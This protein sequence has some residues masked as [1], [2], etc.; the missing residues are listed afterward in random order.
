MDQSAAAGQADHAA[1]KLDVH[2]SGVTQPGQR[3][4]W[5][6][7]RRA[8]PGLRDGPHVVQIPPRPPPLLRELHTQVRGERGDP[9]AAP[10]VLML[11]VQDVLGHQPVEPQ[12]LDTSAA[13]CS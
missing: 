2:R 7:L 9:T 3:A 8:G 13:G 6:P 5:Q 10:T 1:G 11:A 12:H 4:G